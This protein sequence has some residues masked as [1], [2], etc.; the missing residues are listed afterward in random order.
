MVH[1]EVVRVGPVTPLERR[2]INS[3]T[4]LERKEALLA[5]ARLQLAEDEGDK[6]AVCG[7]PALRHCVHCTGA[8]CASCFDAHVRDNSIYFRPGGFYN[9]DDVKNWGIREA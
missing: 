1:S 4:P 9:D 2:L 5:Q 8:F 6:C 7:K 3:L